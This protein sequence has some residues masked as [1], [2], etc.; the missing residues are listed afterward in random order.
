MSEW[1]PEGGAT[2][3]WYPGSDD[4]YADRPVHPT[5]NPLTLGDGTGFGQTWGKPW[6]DP[7]W[8]PIGD[9]FVVQWED[10]TYSTKS[11]QWVSETYDLADCDYGDGV[12]EIMAADE[13]GKL[14]PIHIGQ[15]ERLDNDEEYP[16][17]YF[18][19]SQIYAGNR[20][21]GIVRHTDH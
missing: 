1:Q 12:K 18:A 8:S 9:P 11:E 15:Q 4:D 13:N 17:L 19:H 16:P 6:D 2:L 10:G 20:K 21:A 7:E 3:P 5:G 14:V